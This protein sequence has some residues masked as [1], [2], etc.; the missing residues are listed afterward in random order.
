MYCLPVESFQ[1]DPHSLQA[2]VYLQGMFEILWK[3]LEPLPHLQK[4]V[5]SLHLILVRGLDYL[6]NSIP[7][8]QKGEFMCD[9]IM[10][11]KQMAE[12]SVTQ[13]SNLKLSSEKIIFSPDSQT[14]ELTLMNTHQNLHIYFKVRARISRSRQRSKRCST[15]SQCSGSSGLEKN[16][17]SLS[18]LSRNWYWLCDA[19][20]WGH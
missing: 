19:V 14:A 3:I 5:H 1:R 15:W 2:Y 12:S 4:R 18:S 7:T 17:W 9:W 20:R 16:K 6:S 11:F 10:I 8:D 13:L